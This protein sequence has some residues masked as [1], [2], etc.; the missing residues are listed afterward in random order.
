MPPDLT[1]KFTLVSQHL[2]AGRHEQARQVL[3]RVLQLAPGS[4]E[5]NNGMAIALTNTGQHEQAAFY[6]RRAAELAPN[7]P[8]NLNTLG[9]CLSSS[10]KHAEAIEILTRAVALAPR[11]IVPRVTLTN[12]LW[13]VHR[14][15]D[16]VRVLREGLEIHPFHPDLVYRIAPKLALLVRA[17]EAYDLAAESLKRFPNR[18]DAAWALATSALYHDGL[19]PE[20]VRDAHRKHAEVIGATVSA[21]PRTFANSRD[22]ERSIRVGFLS[23]DLRAHSV[24]YFLEPLLEG[25]D[26]ERFHVICYSNSPQVDDVTKRLKT[27][28]AEWRQVESLNDADLASKIIS[29]RVDVLI[30]LAGY[31]VGHRLNI[32]HMRAA[33]VQGTYCGYACTTGIPA[34]DFRIVDSITDPPEADAWATE[35]LVRLDPPFLCY[36][37]FA[38]APEVRPPP[39]RRASSAGDGAPITFGS[40]NAT[41]KLNDRVIALWS[42]VLTET[43][44]SRL[45]LKG[46]QLRDEGFQGDLR[47][48]FAA[49]GIAPD[50]LA[51]MGQ[52]DSILDHLATYHDI[53]IALDPF[54]YHGTTTTC[55][56]LWMGVP[57]VTL[58]GRAHAQRVGAS[59]LTSVG[60]GELVATSEDEYAAIAR[61]L[62]GDRARLAHQRA[63]LRARMSSSPLLD[64]AGY[65][66]RF[67]GAIR[68]QWRD[69]CEKN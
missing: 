67:G 51:F 4:P 44:R 19:S 21:P 22:P 35:R 69:W 28:V 41:S 43:P 42:R 2:N 32:F 63:S 8:N 65:A 5:A 10:G 26:R 1:A 20:Q 34:I 37:P 7:D 48:R 29:D 61:G 50:R 58:A 13:T 60:L 18:H 52:K 59:L 66:Q 57:V 47:S 12:A 46:L 53:D 16:S 56:A 33:P 11:D 27:L 31:S 17:R 64:Q 14:C 39:S 62:A 9:S 25:L 49:H 55:E 3:M 38:G 15:T 6:A 40:F 45:V 54:P 23:A 24:T 36:K 68:A 30:D